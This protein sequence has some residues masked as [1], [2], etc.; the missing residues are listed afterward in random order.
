V[1]TGKGPIISLNAF[2]SGFNIDLSMEKVF[3]LGNLAAMT[4]TGTDPIDKALLYTYSYIYNY[5]TTKD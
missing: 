5:I 2:A 3:I 4:D 1:R